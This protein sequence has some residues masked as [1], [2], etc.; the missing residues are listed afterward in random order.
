MQATRQQ[1]IELLNAFTP[2]MGMRYES[3]RITTMGQGDIMR[4]Y[5][6]ALR[7]SSVDHGTGTG[8][9]CNNAHGP[10]KA[11][12]FIEE[13]FWRSYFKGW[14]ELRPSI[15]SDYVV[16]LEGDLAVLEKDKDCVP[17]IAPP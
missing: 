1:A 2:N 16:G 7:Q 13:V 12:K 6:L 15:W 17:T 8:W 10:D 4:V 14:L 9:R 5:A 11:F 3:G